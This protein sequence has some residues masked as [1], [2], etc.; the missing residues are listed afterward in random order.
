MAKIPQAIFGTHLEKVRRDRD[1]VVKVITAIVRGHR[2]VQ[3]EP[4]GAVR[5]VQ[6]WNQLNATDARRVYE[7][8]KGVYAE[9]GRVEEK[10][11]QTLAEV[12][13]KSAGVPMASIAMRDIF[14]PALLGESI[15]RIRK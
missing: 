2:F 9:D 3:R 11:I 15:D 1:E 5:H 10:S 6:E 14:D 13:E 4:E 7:L 12:I 8:S